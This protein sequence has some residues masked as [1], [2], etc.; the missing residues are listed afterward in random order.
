MDENK[1]SNNIPDAPRLTPSPT[2]EINNIKDIKLPPPMTTSTVI[3]DHV[4]K[5]VFS[6][7]KED[8][9]ESIV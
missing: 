3:K 4:S 2:K 7:I 9:T 6:C 1:S 5:C 8:D